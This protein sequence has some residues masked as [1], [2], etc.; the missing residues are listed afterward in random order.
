[1]FVWP[2]PKPAVLAAITILA[3]AFG[4][5]AF[6][7]SKMPR[8][9]RPDRFVKVSRVGGGL[10]SV[11]TDN[12]RILVECYAK[13]TGQ[14][15]SMCNAARTALRN[16]AGTTVTTTQGGVFV[17]RFSTEQGPMD[18]HDPDLIEHDRWQFTGDLT[19]KAN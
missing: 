16:A 4:D 10:D 11:A 7:S 8:N 19:I 2:T 9:V 1:M 14:V 18:F 3:E 15:E 6:V 17:R 12:A 5:Y 13:D